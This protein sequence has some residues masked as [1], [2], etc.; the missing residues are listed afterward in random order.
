[1][2]RFGQ[3]TNRSGTGLGG[4]VTIACPHCTL[5]VEL[6]DRIS[7]TVTCPHCAEPFELT[8][9]VN[10]GVDGF[11]GLALSTLHA[12][13]HRLSGANRATNRGTDV[14]F[15]L[16]LVFFGLPITIWWLAGMPSIR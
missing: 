7:G 12:L 4:M 10:A 8:A 3:T 14:V 2:R 6:N 16:A 15:W 9:M 11:S 5:N 1:M 13:R